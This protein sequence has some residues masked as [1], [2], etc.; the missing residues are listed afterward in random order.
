MEN[1]EE[2]G[3][4]RNINHAAEL[5]KSYLNENT[6]GTVGVLLRNLIASNDVNNPLRNAITNTLSNQVN[7]AIR[8]KTTLSNITIS[9]YL[10][11]EEQIDLQKNFPEFDIRFSSTNLNSH[12]FAAAS[13][14]LERRVLLSKLYVDVNKEY[15]NN[16]D[17]R[18]KEI[19][20]D[21]ITSVN[22]GEIG[23]HCCSPLLS[24]YDATRYCNRMGLCQELL[25]KGI[26]KTNYIK[27]MLVHYSKNINRQ[28][29][30]YYCF[31][32]S[33]ECYIQSRNM[34]ALHS[35][36]DIKLHDLGTAMQNANALRLFGCMIYDPIIL[37]QDEGKIPVINA[38]FKVERDS[39]GK[40]KYI[41]FGFLNCD[42]FN[43]VHDY[44]IYIS[45]FTYSQFASNDGKNLYS[46]ELLENR[47][48]VQFFRA[49][50]LVNNLS[51]PVTHRL[52]LKHFSD[53]YIVRFP[54]LDYNNVSNSLSFWDK[55][56]K[57]NNQFNIPTL[58]RF[59]L[60]LP[61]N[62][63]W[64]TTVVR[65]SIIDRT[66][67]Y[68]LGNT[69]EKF[70]PE[71]I[72][73]Y[74]RSVYTRE[75][76][77]S[78]VTSKDELPGPKQ[79]YAIAHAIYVTLYHSKY[80]FG[81]AL[82]QGILEVAA[83]R[84]N[85]TSK[86]ILSEFEY[87][88]RW[89]EYLFPFLFSKKTTT[90]DPQ[91]FI[92]EIVDYVEIV[93][94]RDSKGNRFKRSI[95]S[96][97]DD[98]T[99][100][101]IGNNIIIEDQVEE[102]VPELVNIS[103]VKVEPYRRVRLPKK[104]KD[105]F[106]LLGII[107]NF[108]KFKCGS[109]IKGI[110]TPGIVEA[111][112]FYNYEI[113]ATPEMIWSQDEWLLNDVYPDIRHI[114]N[115]KRSKKVKNF[116][117]E[118]LIDIR[119]L[120]ELTEVDSS[121]VIREKEKDNAEV[122]ETVSIVSDKS[123]EIE[124]TWNSMVE[125]EELICNY[126]A[127]GIY[128]EIGIDVDGSKNDCLF[129]ASHE[130]RDIIPD[131][132]RSELLMDFPNDKEIKQECLAG[133]YAGRRVLEIISKKYNI[134]YV[135]KSD[136][137]TTV[138]CECLNPVRNIHLRLHKNHYYY[139]PTC[140]LKFTVKHRRLKMFLPFDYTINISKI[141]KKFKILGL[142]EI[143]N[144]RSVKSGIYYYNN[145]SKTCT[146]HDYCHS[147]RINV[148]CDYVK[149]VKD[150]FI[151]L[152]IF[153]ET[154]NIELNSIVDYLN[155]NPE[156]GIRFLDYYL[157]GY[158]PLILH[159]NNRKDQSDFITRFEYYCKHRGCNSS[160][161]LEIDET[162]TFYKFCSTVKKNY[163]TGHAESADLTIYLSEGST[164]A[165]IEVRSRSE[166]NLISS[167]VNG[168]CSHPNTVATCLH[169]FLKTHFRYSIIQIISGFSNIQ[170]IITLCKEYSDK[171]FV[172]TTAVS[173]ISGSLVSYY[174][175]SDINNKAKNC[176][177]EVYSLWLDEKN[178]VKNR[179]INV[180]KVL[181][182]SH[183]HGNTVNNTLFDNSACLFDT[184]KMRFVFN[185]R[186]TSNYNWGL[187]NG[188]LINT[189]GLFRKNKVDVEFCKSLVKQ[190]YKYI[191]F[192][193]STRMIHGIE[194]SSLYNLNDIAKFKL[195]EIKIVQGVPGA[196]K[197]E[198]ILKSNENKDNNLLL[199]VTKEARNDMRRRAEKRKDFRMAVE[200]HV[201]TVDSV[202]LN[203][204]T[205]IQVDELWL[206]E[207]LLVHAGTWFWLAEV[208]NCNTLVIVGDK[209][210]IPYIN[211][212][213]KICVY[214]KFECV[215]NSIEL[216]VNRRNP[217][218]VVSWLHNERFYPFDVTGTSS[219]L[220]SVNVL[221]INGPNDIP[222]DYN[223]TYLTFTQGE[224]STLINSGFVNI[225]DG[226]ENCINRKNVKKVC[227]IHE[228]QGSQNKKIILVRLINKHADTIY[229][230][231]PHQ[232]VAI[233][234][235]SAEFLYCTVV[236]D[237]MCEIIQK[238]NRYSDMVIKS[239]ISDLKGGSTRIIKPDSATIMYQ[240]NKEWR[241]ILSRNGQTGYIPTYFYV[242]HEFDEIN[243][244]FD[245]FST[246]GDYNAV[247]TFIDHLLPG[248]STEFNEHDH[249]HF[250]YTKQI[251]EG[252]VSIRLTMPT[253]KKYDYLVPKIRSAIQPPLHL[254]QKLS[255]KAFLER[256]GNVPQLQGLVDDFSVAKELMNDFVKLLDRKPKYNE[257]L[258]IPNIKSME[259]WMRTQPQS[260][261]N[262][263]IS[264]DHF[265]DIEMN[266]YDFIIKS[267]PKIDLEYNSQLRY[268]APQTIAFQKKTVNSIFCP[269]LKDFMD[270]V[271]YSLNDNIVLYNSMSPEEFA[272]LL[273]IRFPLSKYK[274][275]NKFLE[276]DFSK[277]DKSQGLTL[278]IF[279]AILL[280][281]FGLPLYYI[282]IWIIMHRYTTL[283]DH[284]N[285][286]SANIQYQRKSGDAGTWRLNTLVQ[287]ALL[288]NVYKLY[289][290][291]SLDSCVCLFS[292]DDSLIFHERT[293]DMIEERTYSLQTKFNMEAKIVNYKVPYFCSKFL[294]HD[295]NKWLFVPDFLKLCVKLGRKDMVD[296]EHVEMYRISFLDNLY[297]F[298]FRRNW[299][300]INEAINDRYKVKGE[301]DYAFDNL[302]KI[303]LSR[304][305]FK[306]LYYCGIGFVKGN[307]TTKPNLEI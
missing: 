148:Y 284:K 78:S 180:A 295:G 49:S 53:C 71:H 54:F 307:I 262:Q 177:T 24:N 252:E 36:Y 58:K 145:L 291:I 233:T 57:K 132:I 191:V 296:E 73:N 131:A 81:K 19:G 110:F 217:L 225:F 232:L 20:G 47:S 88:K 226:D 273:D 130:D 303:A 279:E 52:Y 241:E 87:N 287:V 254:S 257:H 163:E 301:H 192:A 265:Q 268:K 23:V 25:E 190:N 218:D 121:N 146:I 259:N 63:E 165:K 150:N 203:G 102:I 84:N 93:T 64:V 51:M 111:N 39:N 98:I 236:K 33:E 271:I 142:D 97:C 228:Y 99:F 285:G 139:L 40:R 175:D 96:F 127:L 293:I 125:E 195:P 15:H 211:R 253:F 174:P 216:S 306:N 106:F 170:L 37:M 6:N 298:R 17:V 95:I 116:N 164:N 26:F 32:K 90:F 136:K 70:K 103:K 248:S 255:L 189:E 28:S 246:G 13:R 83:L 219:V 7:K 261:V 8:D 1:D 173:N 260:I 249:N 82:Q 267:L 178:S 72:L 76:A 16:V 137:D 104:S 239:R 114:F 245:D 197:T 101:Y 154:S 272:Q 9:E 138:I 294:I 118:I 61:P 45:Y 69:E 152:L 286:L 247:Q 149:N 169:K 147:N 171:L 89:Y 109:K 21:I 251:L 229:S 278:L 220:H 289:D 194:L 134:R 41:K 124:L 237:T 188:E 79:L 302:V 44:N 274:K 126:P 250:E 198:F 186:V 34:M 55:K 297:Y 209:A 22:S 3:N 206:D 123:D 159:N 157:D 264:E 62:T 243:K 156:V 108:K 266:L 135:I 2:N 56:I 48:G 193:N 207:A 199:T 29:N 277:Y 275:C 75:I 4:E 181:L 242:K 120:F 168:I 11:T 304:E 223:A 300:F 288:N 200:D 35:T 46:L 115:I 212:D 42:G 280:E 12:G 231:K 74:L 143:S 244:D 205:N 214:S 155:A 38:E 10:T 65:K 140:D 27:D 240:Q 68:C 183:L 160:R 94:T 210:Q 161:Y 208:T 221:N 263:I 162:Y 269:L 153:I 204:C 5:T 230:S 276:I 112:P 86:N 176:M 258:I 282:K 187:S 50:S 256:N 128:R 60:T 129:L 59:W 43:Y 141:K 283:I 133:A 179:L 270:R 91:L 167:G 196:G 30:S 67:A 158:I 31:N 85:C 77:V 151:G 14:K 117:E 113:K 235:H 182:D 305:R 222:T 224:K 290:H 172:H 166:I 202:L 201:R 107:K 80:I 215:K 299:I 105:K 185:A 100:E 234:R 119:N 92:S 144:I 122:S 18:V 227:T 292:G 238:I 66:C 184:I 213:G 281:Y